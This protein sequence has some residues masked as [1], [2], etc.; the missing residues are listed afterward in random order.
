[1]IN[2]AKNA[3]LLYRQCSRKAKLIVP[4]LAVAMSLALTLDVNPST[5]SGIQFLGF[6]RLILAFVVSCGLSFYAAI[7]L[8]RRMGK[9]ALIS[10]PTLACSLLYSA[11]TLLG[12]ALQASS[13]FA[14]LYLDSLHV[15]W[16]AFRYLGLACFAYCLLSALMNICRAARAGNAKDKSSWP[17]KLPRTVLFTLIIAASWL[18]WFILFYPGA[19]PTDTARQLAQFF[20]TGDTVLDN[21][22]PYFTSLV[23]GSIYRL[24]MMLTSDCVLSIALL[25]LLQIIIGSIIFG[26]VIKWVDELGAPRW[27]TL[28]SLA[29]CAGFPL[30]SS[31]AITISKD[32]LHACLVSLFALQVLLRWVYR[33]SATP[34]LS[35]WCALVLVATLVAL[36]RNN[37]VFISIPTLLALAIATRSTRGIGSFA[38]SLLCVALWQTVVLP[39]AR[40][41][42]GETGEALSAPSQIVGRA[43]SLDY[44]LT[45]EEW[46][47]LNDSFHVDLNALAETYNPQLS[48]MMKGSLNTGEDLDV[49]AFLNVSLSIALRYPGDTLAAVLNTTYG[50]WY[51]FDLGTYWQ[52]EGAPYWCAPD[53]AYGLLGTWFA[54]HE[55]VNTWSVEHANLIATLQNLRINTSV[56]TFLYRPGTYIWLLLFCLCASFSEKRHRG[57]TAI[58]I[59]PF[60]LLFATLLA[61][62]CSSIRYSLPFIFS[63]PI[64]LLLL[65]GRLEKPIPQRRHH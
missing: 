1:M 41:Q 10:V 37:G 22:F 19:V 45:D 64:Y 65:F 27:V 17:T 15:A 58:T 46:R 48:D 39:F 35:S 44:P 50:F 34:L 8:Q 32:F 54:D 14:I 3:A 28:L 33:D 53:D 13:S 20:G 30:F 57:V 43:L 55:L 18:I 9:E 47:V 2:A 49:P 6:R 11:F 7:R 16:A 38:V 40:V 52:A 31:H 29:F 59:L 42:P 62:P 36:T 5:G 21:H 24:G 61:G 25:A 26:T 63:L 4:V 12:Q 56:L 23:F 60:V 51:P